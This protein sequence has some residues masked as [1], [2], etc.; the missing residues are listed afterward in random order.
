[1]SVTAIEEGRS[2]KAVPMKKNFTAMHENVVA[3]TQG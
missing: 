1:M 2:T 3:S